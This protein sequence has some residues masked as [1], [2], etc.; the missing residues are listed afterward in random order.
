ML[1][2]VMK[3][4]AFLSGFGHFIQKSR[5]TAS[6]YAY[7]VF[8]SAFLDGLEI[9]RA[10]EKFLEICHRKVSK[11]LFVV[12][13]TSDLSWDFGHFVQKSQ[14]SLQFLYVLHLFPIGFRRFKKFSGARSIL[15]GEALL[16][17]Q[18]M[19]PFTGSDAKIGI[20][21][22]IICLRHRACCRQ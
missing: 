17:L 5:R 11:M 21:I 1:S 18:R 13:K 19:P 3:T 15:L 14:R 6:I 8:L 12:V 2:G 9:S 22:N 7:F 20:Y 4:S 10:S 16:H